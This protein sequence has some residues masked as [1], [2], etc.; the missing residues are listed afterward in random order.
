ML[1]VDDL[2]LIRISPAQHAPR[3]SKHSII[4]VVREIFVLLSASMAINCCKIIEPRK[5]IARIT[6]ICELVYPLSNRKT[7]AYPIKMQ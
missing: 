2:D 5:P 6:P 4:I 7:L 1:R 3:Q